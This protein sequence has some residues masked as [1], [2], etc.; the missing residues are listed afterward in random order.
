MYENEDSLR[1][2]HEQTRNHTFTIANND[3]IN[4]NETL[5]ETN[6]STKKKKDSE[7]EVTLISDNSNQTVECLEENILKTNDNID[8]SLDSK[9]TT[10]NLESGIDKSENDDDDDDDDE[11]EEEQD[12]DDDEDQDDY[13][14]NQYYYAMEYDYDDDDEYDY[15]GYGYENEDEPSEDEEANRGYLEL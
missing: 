6:D 7:L 1:E 11:E 4:T 12:D 5:S 13:R 14:E 2:L 15:E 3:V 9:K 8:I 10:M